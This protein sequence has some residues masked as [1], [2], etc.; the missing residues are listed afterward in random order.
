MGRDVAPSLPTFLKTR[1]R[2]YVPK[3][4]TPLAS[5]Y[6]FMPLLVMSPAGFCI[7]S[8]VVLSLIA[9]TAKTVLL[10]GDCKGTENADEVKKLFQESA[11]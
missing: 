7:W 3:D 11:S 6:T 8:A 4:E 2:R 9:L 10:L 5:P 1:S